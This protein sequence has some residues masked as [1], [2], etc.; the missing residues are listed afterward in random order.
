[1]WRIIMFKKIIFSIVLSV[2]CGVVFAGAMVQAVDRPVA[3]SST[4]EKVYYE[5]DRARAPEANYQHEGMRIQRA[6]M[7]PMEVQEQPLTAKAVK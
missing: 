1:M 7:A 5:R 3:V 2:G 6:R 4:S